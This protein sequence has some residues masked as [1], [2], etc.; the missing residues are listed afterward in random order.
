MRTIYS[1]RIKIVRSSPYDPV[2]S[3]KW[4]C[5]GGEPYQDKVALIYEITVSELEVDEIE[6]EINELSQKVKVL[7]VERVLVE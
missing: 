6:R 1:Y 7:E 3:N 4:I 5:I 2:P